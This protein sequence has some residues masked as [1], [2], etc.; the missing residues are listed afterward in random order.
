MLRAISSA[1]ILL[2]APIAAAHADGDAA[3]G[4]KV[5]NRCMACHEATT[6]HDKVG[7]H[8]LG[9][10]GRTAGKAQNFNYSQAMKDAGAAG[11][12]WD[13][14]NLSLYLRAPKLKVPGNK[15][16]FSGLTNDADIANV[17][18]YLKADPKP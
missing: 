18:A 6:D 17:I 4:K 9:V 16:A 3:L 2:L 14:A 12:V 13:E 15:M 5:F 1:A 7:P 8:L 10:V 11:L